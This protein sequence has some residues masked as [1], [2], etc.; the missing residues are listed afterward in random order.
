MLCSLKVSC[1]IVCMWNSGH[2]VWS[3]LCKLDTP[4]CHFLLTKSHRAAEWSSYPKEKKG[5]IKS[6]SCDRT[7]WAS[8]PPHKDY[9]NCNNELIIHYRRIPPVR[10]SHAYLW[11]LTSVR[12]VTWA[13]GLNWWIR[14]LSTLW[15]PLKFRFLH[16]WQSSRQTWDG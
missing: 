12:C 7:N 9:N 16:S 14:E 6:F 3:C 11:K 15:N 8:V 2:N 13:N 5:L 1:P 4:S 10:L